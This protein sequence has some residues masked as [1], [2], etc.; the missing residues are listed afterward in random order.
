L[1]VRALEVPFLEVAPDRLTLSLGE[2]ARQA[3]STATFSQGDLSVDL[4]ILSASHQVLVARCDTELLS[5]TVACGDEA[6]PELPRQMGATEPFRFASMTS[7][8]KP[9]QFQDE[10]EALLQDVMVAPMA[11]CGRFPGVPL[12]V[13]AVVLTAL[14]SEYVAWRTWH[15]YPQCSTIVATHSELDL[16]AESRHE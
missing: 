15:T 11:L 1:S 14:G 4:R 2:P 7:I 10:V 3:L 5:E 9:A 8:L 12:S 13:T 16:I 6:S